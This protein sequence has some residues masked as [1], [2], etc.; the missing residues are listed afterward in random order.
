MFGILLVLGQGAIVLAALHVAK[1]FGEYA[2]SNALLSQQI[3]DALAEIARIKAETI[4][5]HRSR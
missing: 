4:N 5:A 1:R 3:V 2:A